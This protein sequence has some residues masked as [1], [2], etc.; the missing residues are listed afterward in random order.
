ME[1][2]KSHKEAIG[3]SGLNPE[4]GFKESVL[5]SLSEGIV[6]LIIGTWAFSDNFFRGVHQFWPSITRGGWVWGG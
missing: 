1:D 2:A 5:T 3:L 6:D 4:C